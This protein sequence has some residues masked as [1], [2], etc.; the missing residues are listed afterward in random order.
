MAETRRSTCPRARERIIACAEPTEE[1]RPDFLVIMHT[2]RSIGAWGLQVRF[3]SNREK[4]RVTLSP[5][6]CCLWFAGVLLPAA[7]WAQTP[8]SEDWN[9]K[10]QA[11][12][13]WQYKRPFAAA[14][15][16][17]NSLSS[18][19]ERSY[20]FSST[21]FL[22]FRPWTGGEFYINPQ[23]SQSTPFSHQTG[24]GGFTSGDVSATHEGPPPTLSLTR[25]FLRQTLGV[26]RRQ[27]GDRVGR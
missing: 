13:I 19:R 15:S 4:S 10:F 8:E 5:K 18:E 23:M 12:Y 24:L 11:T 3:A 22:G 9:A 20:S 17:L 7:C 27:G 16:G 6:Q 26:R 25:I 14:Y 1:R 2:P 21:G